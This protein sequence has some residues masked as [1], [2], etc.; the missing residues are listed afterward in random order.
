VT[1]FGHFNPWLFF[2]TITVAIGGG[3][4]STFNINTGDPIINGVQVLAGLGSACVIQMVSSLD[5]NSDY[6]KLL[7]MSSLSSH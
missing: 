7:I 4:L 5:A 2:G 3:L 1:K 6:D